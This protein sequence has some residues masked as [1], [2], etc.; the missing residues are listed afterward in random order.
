MNI[1]KGQKRDIKEHHTFE[2][3]I[4]LLSLVAPKGAVCLSERLPTW[5]KHKH[6]HKHKGKSYFYAYAMS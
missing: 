5:H 1:K 6:K 2:L 4:A 3:V